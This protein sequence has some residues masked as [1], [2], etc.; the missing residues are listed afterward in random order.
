[1]EDSEI[2]LKKSPA[3]MMTAAAKIMIFTKSGNTLTWLELAENSN[4]QTVFIRAGCYRKS[5]PAVS[6]T[7]V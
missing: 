3:T 5:I 4:T 1:M 6:L 7:L 2:Y